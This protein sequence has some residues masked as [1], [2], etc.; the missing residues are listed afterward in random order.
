MS[1]PREHLHTV[2][3]WKTM[4]MND[5]ESEILAHADE[6]LLTLN[7][8][9]DFIRRNPRAGIPLSS[10]DDILHGLESNPERTIRERRM[11]KRLLDLFMKV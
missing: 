7:R 6:L 4:F 10:I 1:S 3:S 9:H 11:R 8:L 5:D 2:S